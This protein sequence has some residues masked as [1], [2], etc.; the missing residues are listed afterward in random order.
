MVNMRIQRPRMRSEL[1]ALKDC[2]PP[3]TCAMA[4]VR[5]WVGRTLPVE[6]GIQSIWFLKTAVCGR[7]FVVSVV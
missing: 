6:S 2:E 5:P 7:S 4:R 3:F 1:T